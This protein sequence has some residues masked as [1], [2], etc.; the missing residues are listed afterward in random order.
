MRRSFS[1]GHLNR[2]A[3]KQVNLERPEEESEELLVLGRVQ[4][5]EDFMRSGTGA[6][7]LSEVLR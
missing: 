6:I 3:E 5:D 2:Q 1:L 4:V 7:G